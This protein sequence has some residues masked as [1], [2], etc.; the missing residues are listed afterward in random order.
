MSYCYQ[1]AIRSIGF[2]VC[3]ERNSQKVLVDRLHEMSEC[4]RSN[5]NQYYWHYQLPYRA[6]QQSRIRSADWAESFRNRISDVTKCV[7]IFY[8]RIWFR[9]SDAVVYKLECCESIIG[10]NS[11]VRIHQICKGI[12]SGPGVHPPLLYKP[13]SIISSISFDE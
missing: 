1:F 3:N 5:V 6:E 9:T 8:S 12:A 11:P 10:W 4:A 2:T 13:N 7:K